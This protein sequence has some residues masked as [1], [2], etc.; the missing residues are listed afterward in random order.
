MTDFQ[1]NAE[2]M[3]EIKTAALL[4]AFSVIACLAI[5]AGAVVLIT[6]WWLS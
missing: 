1:T 4:I 3:E 6:R 2:Q 5:F